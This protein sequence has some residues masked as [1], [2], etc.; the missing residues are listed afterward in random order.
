MSALPRQYAARVTS[1]RDKVPGLDR[2]PF[3]LPVVPSLGHIELMKD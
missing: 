3:S 1:M 2:Y